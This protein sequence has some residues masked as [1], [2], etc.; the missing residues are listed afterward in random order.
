M[1]SSWMFFNAQMGAYAIAL[2]W[3][4]FFVMT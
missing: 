4:G 2:D 3:G 1:E